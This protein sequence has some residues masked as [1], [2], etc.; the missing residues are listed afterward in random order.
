MLQYIMDACGDSQLCF[1]S[2]FFPLFQLSKISVSLGRQPHTQ[3]LER[4]DIKVYIYITL[5]MYI[6]V[7]QPGPFAT[8]YHLSCI[9]LFS[10]CCVYI[11]NFI[12][13]NIV[14]IVQSV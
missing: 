13:L 12:S 4:E 10:L 1:F 3:L 9:Y 6:Y 14:G 11:Q 2:P 8:N 5:E 7:P